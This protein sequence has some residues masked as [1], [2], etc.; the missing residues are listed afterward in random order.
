MANF[1]DQLAAALIELLEISKTDAWNGSMR[2]D[3]AL[4]DARKALDHYHA[5]RDDGPDNWT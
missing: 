3:D 5:D 1:S 2:L 4:E